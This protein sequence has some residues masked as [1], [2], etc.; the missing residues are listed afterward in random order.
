MSRWWLAAAVMLAWFGALGWLIARER[1]AGGEA[2]ELAA[3]ARRVGPASAYYAVEL[4]GRQVGLATSTADTSP[5]G[6]RLALHYDVSLPVGDSVVRMLLGEQ[7]DLTRELALRSFSAGLR[8]GGGALTSSGAVRYGLLD[9]TVAESR[10][11]TA[12]ARFA[13]PHGAVSRSSIP[14]RVA[15]SGRMEPGTRLDLPMIDPLAGRPWTA[16]VRIGRD[17]LFTVADSATLDSTTHR[18]SVAHQDTVRAWRIEVAGGGAPAGLWVDAQGQLVEAAT[19]DGFVLRRSPFELV[20]QAY[21]PRA[22]APA[23]SGAL[24]VPVAGP[25]DHVPAHADRLILL[26]GLGYDAG[27]WSGSALD[28]A[29]QALRGDTLAISRAGG[30]LASAYLLPNGDTTFA[31]ALSPDALVPSRDAAMLSQARRIAG[32]ERRPRVVASLLTGWVARSVARDG[33]G[34]A[35]PIRALAVRRGDASAHAALLVAFARALGLPA[36]LAGGAV[37]DRGR[38]WY[39][40]W[41]ELW[42][43]GWVPADPWIGTL[44]AE[45]S[46]LRLVTDAP[47]RP[48]QVVPLLQRL[49]PRVLSSAETR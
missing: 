31:A 27:R 35:D 19:A 10:A 2:R 15:F 44:P 36:R 47:G 32:A 14:L 34:P 3:N 6:V 39:H 13:L 30:R 17:S 11:D 23:D 16:D 29:G 8:S 24:A 25:L 5:Q 45:A 49:A 38:W 12:A 41:A 9:W 28:G 42:L 33:R 18:W 1:A 37:Y 46:Y 20:T 40:S 43:D 48:F 21:R 7:V 22:G 26:L 4:S